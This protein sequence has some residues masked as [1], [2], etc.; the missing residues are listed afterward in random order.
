MDLLSIDGLTTDWR[1][2]RS[3]FSFFAPKLIQKIARAMKHDTTFWA[4]FKNFIEVFVGCVP[5]PPGNKKLTNGSWHRA[6]TKGGNR[7][8]TG[9]RNCIHDLDQRTR[10]CARICVAAKRKKEEHENK[11]RRFQNK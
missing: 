5:F 11:I 2:S 8:L 1:H 10:I 3:L 7:E 9:D 6:D 4:H